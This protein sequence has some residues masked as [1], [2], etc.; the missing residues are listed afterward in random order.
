MLDLIFAWESLPQILRGVPVTLLITATSMIVAMPISFLIALARINRVPVVSQ[1]FAVYV[2]FI[3][4]TPLLVQIYLL[5]FSLPRML[6]AFFASI[7][8]GISLSGENPLGYAILIFILN[9][10]GY[11]AETFRSAIQSVPSGQMEAALSAGLTS[12]QGYYRVVIPQALVV[13]LPSMCNTVQSI[14]KGTSLA[15]VIGVVEIMAE[16]KLAAAYETRYIEAY[17]VVFVVYLVV[18][19]CIEKMFS[20]LENHFKRYKVL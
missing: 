17:L 13:A 10:S 8:F 19:L 5:Y 20:V 9:T 15:F 7:G 2:S 18:C 11:L 1:V 3:R 14:L 12:F 4:G 16:G 6:N